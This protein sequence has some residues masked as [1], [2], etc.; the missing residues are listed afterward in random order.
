MLRRMLDARPLVAMIVAAGVG[1]WGLSAYPLPMDNVFL[2]IIALRN[3]PVLQLL[4]YTYATGWFTTPFLAT[5]SAPVLSAAW[6]KRTSRARRHGRRTRRGSRSR[7]G[8]C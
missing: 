3:P 8:A 7:S 2:E 5:S 6:A 4:G 1:T